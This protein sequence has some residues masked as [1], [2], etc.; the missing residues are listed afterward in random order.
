MFC[1]HKNI[2]LKREITTTTVGNSKRK[3]EQGK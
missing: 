3:Y 1:L 2:F